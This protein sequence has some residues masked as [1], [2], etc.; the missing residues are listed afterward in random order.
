MKKDIQ[1][2]VK[3]AYKLVKR[4]ELDTFIIKFIHMS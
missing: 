2:Y 3:K 4:H 1:N